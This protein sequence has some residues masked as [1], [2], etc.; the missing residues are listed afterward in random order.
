MAEV[1]GP[2]IV[3]E[4]LVLYLDAADK[5]SYPGSGITWSDL[6]GNGN[7]GT[8]TNGPTFNS[9]NNGS[10]VFDGSNDYV[11]LGLKT[12]GNLLD[13]AIGSSF[14]IWIN[15]DVLPPTGVE[16]YTSFL[17][18]IQSNTL[19]NLTFIGSSISVGGRSQVSDSYQNATF[20]YTFTNTWV[21]VSGILDYT[22]KTISIY[23]NGSLGIVKTVSFGSNS[24]IMGIPT[25]DDN[26]GRLS[27]GVQHFNGKISNLTVYNRAL[28]A[29][30][31][32]QN[33]NATKTRFG[34]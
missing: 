16:N 29:Q 13:G 20:P 19:I 30:E 31:I 27:S 3:R 24:I 21:N 6:S 1:Y 2:K 12:V 26:I 17:F 34:L 33:Y 9:D 18:V 22:A 10:L 7:T 14:S 4:G 28:T 8:L 32:Q 23:V 11:N 15:N 25:L 5:T